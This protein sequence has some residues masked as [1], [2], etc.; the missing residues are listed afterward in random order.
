MNSRAFS[1]LKTDPTMANV[2]WMNAYSGTGNEAVLGVATSKTNATGVI[3]AFDDPSITVAQG[4]SLTTYG[5]NDY[6]VLGLAP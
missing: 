2:L 1:P 3:G 5:S 6:F 4:Q